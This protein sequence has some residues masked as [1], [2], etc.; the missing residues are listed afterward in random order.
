MRGSVARTAKC[1]KV[2]LGICTAVTAKLFVVN[3]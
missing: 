1:N 3:L 2:V